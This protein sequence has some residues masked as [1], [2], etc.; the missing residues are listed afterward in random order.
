LAFLLSQHI[1]VRLLP[2]LLLLSPLLG[3]LLVDFLGL[4][5]LLLLDGS[6]Q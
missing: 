6:I 3:K 1:L 5:P 2:E 4:I